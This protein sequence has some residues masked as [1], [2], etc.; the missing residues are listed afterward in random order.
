MAIYHL[1]VCPVFAAG[2]AR[3]RSAHHGAHT[4]TTRG[5]SGKSAYLAG[6]RRIAH[7]GTVIDYSSKREAI[8]HAQLVLPGGGSTDRN[9]F[10]NTVDTRR[11]RRDAKNPTVARDMIIALP[12]ELSFE[13]RRELCNGMARWIADTYSVAVDYGMHRHTEA[14]LLAGS[15]R[16]NL[17]C[18]FL[19]SERTV[20]STGEVGNVQRAFNQRACKAARRPTAVQEIRHRWQELANE[21]LERHG[22]AERIDCRTYKEQG[23]DK[24][25]GEHRGRH[26]T[27][28]LRSAESLRAAIDDFNNRQAAILDDAEK[29]LLGFAAARETVGGGAYISGRI[30]DIAAWQQDPL[31][32]LL[33]CSEREDKATEIRSKLHGRAQLLRPLAPDERA[34]IREQNR[35]RA[36]GVKAREL[37]RK[38]AI[39][40]EKFEG[41]LDMIDGEMTKGRLARIT[42]LLARHG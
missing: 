11:A 33:R 15:D 35:R 18:H 42:N 36:D 37:G 24:T 16:R 23:I 27:L 34:L 29:S 9:E 17:H 32:Q 21:A 8:E 3:G 26:A 38:A 31:A 19:M 28:Q 30:G 7:D 2:S 1:R 22:C 12:H 10:W 4:L 41:S 20:S 6:E 25:P 13:A 40:L 14:E 39:A 5:A